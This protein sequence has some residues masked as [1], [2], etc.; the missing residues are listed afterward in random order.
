MGRLS[1][2]ISCLICNYSLQFS[3]LELSKIDWRIL[4]LVLKIKNQLGTGSK[5]LNGH[6][7]VKCFHITVNFCFSKSDFHQGKSRK[8]L[9]TVNISL[10]G[11]IQQ[12]NFLPWNNLGLNQCCES[13][14]QILRH[15][16]H[17]I[18][19]LGTL[20]SNLSK[21]NTMVL[22]NSYLLTLCRNVAFPK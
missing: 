17:W 8:C 16:F 12:R 7:T 3:S 18:F 21:W 4:N 1:Q 6:Q 5:S 22:G 19:E 11:P 9:A 13:T 10:Q 15:L 2:F 14:F 20:N